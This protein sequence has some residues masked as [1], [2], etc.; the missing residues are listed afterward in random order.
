MDS[1]V[2][3]NEE[4]CASLR[5]MERH[6]LE[7][8]REEAKNIEAKVDAVVGALERE[9]VRELWPGAPDDLSAALG[10][11]ALSSPTHLLS[12]REDDFDFDAP[13]EEVRRGSHTHGLVAAALDLDQ[14]VGGYREDD[15]GF[16]VPGE[17]VRRGGE[18]AQFMD[19][20]RSRPADPLEDICALLQ[21]AGENGID[22]NRWLTHYDKTGTGVLKKKDLRKA[23]TSLGLG[24]LPEGETTAERALTGDAFG[25]LVDY[26]GGRQD[27]DV[28]PY[29]RLLTMVPSMG[30]PKRSPATSSPAL[31]PPRA[32]SPPAGR[33]SPRS[34][35][36]NRRP[37]K[38]GGQRQQ[39]HGLATAEDPGQSPHANV[40]ASRSAHR[41]A[42]VAREVEALQALPPDM[43]ATIGQNRAR[44]RVRKRAAAERTAARKD[45]SLALQKTSR[46]EKKLCD[47]VSLTAKMQRVT[48]RRRKKKED[49]KAKA[50]SMQLALQDSSTLEDLIRARLSTRSAFGAFLKALKVRDHAGLVTHREKVSGKVVARVVRECT[51]LDLPRSAMEK[52]MLGADKCMREDP[53]W[54]KSQ[55]VPDDEGVVV[56]DVPT[57][58]WSTRTKCPVEFVEKYF[59]RVRCK[60]RIAYNKWTRSKGAAA[61]LALKTLSST[62]EEALAGDIEALQNIQPDILRLEKSAKC[63]LGEGEGDGASGAAADF[64]VDASSAAAAASAGGTTVDEDGQS[65]TRKTTRVRRELRLRKILPMWQVKAAAEDITDK[66]LKSLEGRA[67]VRH[68]AWAQSNAG[69]TLDKAVEPDAG[70]LSTAG[71]KLREER[72]SKLVDGAG[73]GGGGGS[74]TSEAAASPSPGGPG[75]FYEMLSHKLFGEFLREMISNSEDWLKQNVRNTLKS[76]PK[77]PFDEW[78]QRRNEQTLR[79]KETVAQWRRHKTAQFAQSHVRRVAVVND[80]VRCVRELEQMSYREVSDA[81]LGKTRKAARVGLDIGVCLQEIRKIGMENLAAATPKPSGKGGRR[82]FKKSSANQPR[83]NGDWITLRQFLRVM[84]QRLFSLK[85]YPPT[86][87]MAGCLLRGELEDG[88]MLFVITREP[89]DSVPSIALE[90]SSELKKEHAERNK[91]YKKWI[92]QKAALRKKEAR[93]LSKTRTKE[94]QRKSKIRKESAKAVKQW[95]KI[96]EK[97]KSPTRFTPRAA[98]ADVYT[99]PDERDEWDSGRM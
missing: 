56:D 40:L 61:S 73:G 62:I 4:T 21:A 58:Q 28:V 69:R 36:A 1:R 66:W 60:T 79:N 12:R 80:V 72:L 44:E 55:P 57:K 16:G 68:A 84:E 91:A 82:R 77:R 99:A 97:R 35:A 90:R 33:R 3:V 11:I 10:N 22:L 30:M 75:A 89:P 39:R 8:Q 43:R 51:G 50:R 37:T 38:G 42:H 5:E 53:N 74:S 31:R 19:D 29:A 26:L 94:N 24:V 6:M 54:Q 46:A 93:L 95:K 41:M 96:V 9:D 98:W 14:P 2:T 70:T 15:F 49:K 48:A 20:G 34:P 18:V 59:R 64:A 87:N 45:E 7:L 25:N 86:A 85:A 81:R 76:W 83:K 47:A 52:I 17:E 65:T 63:A 23:V 71:T 27:V 32:A 67:A 92:L 13:G 78:M 88:K